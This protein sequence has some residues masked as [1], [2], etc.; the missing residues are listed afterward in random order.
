MLSLLFKNPWDS[1]SR[2]FEKQPSLQTYHILSLL[3]VSPPPDKYHGIK[4]PRPAESETNQLGQ[5]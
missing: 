4:P 1:G 3:Q 5:Q 2:F